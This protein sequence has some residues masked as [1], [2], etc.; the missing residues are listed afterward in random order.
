MDKELMNTSQKIKRIRGIL[1]IPQ[2]KLAGKGLDRSTISN[3]E[4]GK[5]ELTHN[6]A[7]IIANNANIIAKRQNIELNVTEKWLM[8]DAVQ[9]AVRIMKS[10][11]DDIKFEYIRKQAKEI[12]ETKE[13][14]KNYLFTLYNIC[15]IR[16]ELNKDIKK[17][18][19]YLLK[20]YAIAPTYYQRIYA[21]KK[22][23]N[24]YFR[25]KQY[26][27]AI[28]YGESSF[29]I[30]KKLKYPK[31]ILTKSIYFN[32]ALAYR[33]LNQLDKCARTLNILDGFHLIIG[34]K[35]DIEFI[36]EDIE[37]EKG[38]LKAAEIMLN[39]IIEKS[40]E[41]N[42][43]YRSI[44]AYV[45]LAKIYS[46]QENPLAVSY[47]KKALQ[48][49][50]PKFKLTFQFKLAEILVYALEVFIKF[51]Y[52]YFEITNIFKALINISS[53]IKNNSIYFKSINIMYCFYESNDEIAGM[54]SL[55]KLLTCI[56][57]NP[58]AGALYYKIL[59]YL[60][61]KND[62]DFKNELMDGFNMISQIQI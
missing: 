34:E 32:L 16:F 53:S 5:I 27:N 30:M 29:H 10:D 2:V 6:I 24:V 4:R 54:K 26:D 15:A 25:L 9:Q 36:K 48:L 51:K 33:Y 46:S 52:D 55:L 58:I 11:L 22:I 44:L 18:E 23:M 3:L 37:R 47:I 13:V 20:M 14:N 28:L 59:T 31:N 17:V 61:S 21:I 56:K 42:D 8:E 12:I 1:G 35:L 41:T 40:K 49:D 39:N 43:E 60:Y 57:E 62:I 45:D 38:N 50:F 7:R 19:S